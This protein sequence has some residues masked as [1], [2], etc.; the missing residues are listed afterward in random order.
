MDHACL[1]ADEGEHLVATIGPENIG[2]LTTG[3]F[4]GPCLP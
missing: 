2:E 4:G 1:A 3:T